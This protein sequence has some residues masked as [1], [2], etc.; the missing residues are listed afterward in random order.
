MISCKKNKTK[1]FCFG[2]LIGIQ[3]N[4]TSLILMKDIYTVAWNITYSIVSLKSLKNS[5]KEKNL[6]CRGTPPVHEQ[7]QTKSQVSYVQC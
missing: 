1:W 4:S 5:T 7:T 3:D 2:I 6:L